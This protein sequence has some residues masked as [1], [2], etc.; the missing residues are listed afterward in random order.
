MNTNLVPRKRVVIKIGS[1]SLTN[2]SGNLSRKKLK[3]F[4][5]E[6]DLLIR[7]G[8]EVI[9]VTSGA[10]AAGS[11]ELNLRAI[12][13]G[14]QLRQA[15]AAVG[16]S[17]LMQMYGSEFGQK[18][19]K[20]AQI[21]ITR[22]DFSVRASYNQ[23]LQTLT[24]LLEHRVIPII[25]ENDT[26]TLP[27]N[28]FGDN[29]MLAALVSSL[30]HADQLVILTD[31]DGVYD[32]NPK[33]FPDATK[34]T[35][36]DEISQELIQA[37]GSS[38]SRFGTGGMYAKIIAAERG[39][40]LGVPVYIGKAESDGDLLKIVEGSGTG[41][42]FEVG[43]KLPARRKLQWI[44]FHSEIKGRVLIDYGAVDAIVSRG[45]SLLP[46]GVRSVSGEFVS[47]DI[48]E[49]LDPAGNILGRGVINYNRQQLASVLGR[50]TEY[51]KSK[52]GVD[53]VEV[54]HRDDWFF[55]GEPR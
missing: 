29:D 6:I 34:L 46:A 26:V 15:A 22:R 2:S 42:Y 43:D 45:K 3:F 37:A 9:I 33:D 30:L 20:V 24:A 31:I 47:G 52:L 10:V 23:A 4:V 51:A 28:T 1:S 39:L 18:K 8:H 55:L 35:N 21:L 27:E 54:I 40:S 7:H 25:N 41:S 14:A 11:G 36:I 50:T 19:R 17:I 49:V 53:R 13:S 44:A 32:S 38:G 16:Q 12:P 48:V 5:K